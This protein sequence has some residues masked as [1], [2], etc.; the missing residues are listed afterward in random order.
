MTADLKGLV[1]SNKLEEAREM[2]EGME[3]NGL[4]DVHQYNMMMAAC[5]SAEACYELMDKMERH[6][7]EHNLVTYNRL[8]K[9]LVAEGKRGKAKGVLDVMRERGMHPNESTFEML[10]GVGEMKRMTTRLKRCKTL[11]RPEDGKSNRECIHP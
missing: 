6:G 9:A 11:S 4:V 10:E 8:I 2:F 7:V 1:Y 5:T 3:R